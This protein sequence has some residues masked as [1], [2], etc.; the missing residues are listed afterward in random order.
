MPWEASGGAGLTRSLLPGTLLL[1]ASTGHRALGQ[2]LRP[3]QGRC[4]GKEPSEPLALCTQQLFLAAELDKG[5]Q[6]LVSEKLGLFK[7][8]FFHLQN[9][10]CLSAQSQHRWMFS[11]F[12]NE[13]ALKKCAQDYLNRVKQ[14]EQRYQALKVHAEEKLDK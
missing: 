2:K 10:F 5:L 13:E 12:Q 9:T 6:P 1:V 14:E 11:I 3:R 8:F 7:A 4:Q